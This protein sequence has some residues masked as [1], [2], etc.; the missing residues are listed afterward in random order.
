MKSAT[1][2]GGLATILHSVPAQVRY[3]S[4]DC[5]DTL[6]WRNMNLPVDLFA[7]L[8]HPGGGM[9]TRIWGETRARRIIPY[10][11]DRDE[12]TIDEIYENMLPAGTA[13][14]RA[15]GIAAELAAE[16]AHCYGFAPT[17][18]LMVDAKRRGLKIIIVSDTYLSEP[19]LR[20]LIAA[21]A[22]QA[23]ADMIDRI[24]CSCE[25]GVSKAGGLFTHVLAEL[26][27]SPA[28]ILH[29]GDN[30]VADQ[31]APE[32]LGIQ[33]VHLEQFDGESDQRLRQ[34]ASI[35]SLVDP[36]TRVTVPA[37]Q[38]HRAAI[39]LR[40]DDE[41][42][43]LLGHDVI[44]PLMTGFADW[45]RAE[46]DAQDA[47]T[48]KATKLLFLLRDGFLPGQVFLARHLDL[49]DRAKMVEVSRFTAAA[50]S[51]TDAEAIERCILPELHMGSLAVFARQLL[52]DRDEV[53]KLKNVSKRQFVKAIA[54]PRRV[55][56]IVRRSG[57]MRD[58][59]I[60]HL[61]SH[62]VE[63]GDSVMLV[64]LGYNGS[65][66]NFLAPVLERD[67]GLTVTGRYLLLR[68]TTRSGHD[69]R[70]FIDDRNHDL[71]LL[72]ALS[73]SIALVEQVSTLAQGSVIDYRR[74]GTPVRKAAG[75]K[76]GQSEVRDAIQKA[77]LD[78]VTRA[79]AG[80]VRPAA[81]DTADARR[82]MCVAILARLLF[83]P[84]Q[85][86]VTLLADFS[87]DVNLGTDDMVRMLDLD[88]ATRGLR[89]RGL[90]Y[91]KNAARMYLPGELRDHGLPI[92][93]SIFASRRFGLDLRKQDFDVGAVPLPVML[94]DADGDHVVIDVDAV[95]TIDGFYQALIPVGEYDYTPGIQLGRIADWVQVEEASFHSVDSFLAAK[96]NE[97]GVTATL[98]YEAMEEAAPG[99][100]RCT[101][102][103]AF[104][105]A[106]LPAVAKRG[107][108][109]LLSFVFRPV[110]TRAEAQQAKPRSVRAA[111]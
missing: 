107:E 110:I 86:E 108:P 96:E 30:P 28:H 109:M 100:H 59:L 75:V 62:G 43:S 1:R 69:K 18:D 104:V 6:L 7:G 94:M 13:E 72:H 51:F 48:G 27:A 56:H 53:N 23:V 5:F 101:G 70:G 57:E 38:P 84:M 105:L 65:V 78:Y 58:R 97:E 80:F 93:L 12:V 15:A 66:Q 35:A 50:A 102:E 90:F 32:K 55:R 19:R 34:E 24:F 98:F 99:L 111:A 45:I 21:A 31:K 16:A 40:P 87:H 77:C 14:E 44:G 81:S 71:K 60:A 74:D 41:P 26:G 20:G 47:A 83:L 49:A 8:D 4:L 92:N 68:E 3:L 37:Y 64:D 89:R 33:T 88:D 10:R 73:E 103:A 22:G 67:M 79:D 42:A 9:E 76:G 46:M 54:D 52:L 91:I 29:V 95:P 85:S 17:R 106:P 61:A 39:A 11:D 2:A 63:R 25:Y 82:R 36:T